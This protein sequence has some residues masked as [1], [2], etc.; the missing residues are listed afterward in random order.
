MDILDPIISNNN[1]DGDIYED[2]MMGQE[3][4]AVQWPTSSIFQLATD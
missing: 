4:F 2:S 1:A 3:D